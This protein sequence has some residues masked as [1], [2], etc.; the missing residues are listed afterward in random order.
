MPIILA[1]VV[2]GVF[3]EILHLILLG[4]G[5]LC[6]VVWIHHKSDNSVY[7]LSV[8]IFLAAYLFF[9]SGLRYVTAIGI[10][11]VWLLWKF[12]I[13]SQQWR[14]QVTSLS[15]AP[16]NG[17]NDPK[18]KFDT[19][20]N[21]IW[22]W[23]ACVM[24][25][26]FIINPQ[27]DLAQRFLFAVLVFSVLGIYYVVFPKFLMSPHLYNRFLNAVF[28]AGVGV[29]VIGLLM[30]FVF[31]T[32]TIQFGSSR[33]GLTSEGFSGL[34]FISASLYY[35][36]NTTALVYVIAIPVGLILLTRP[37]AQVDSHLS[38]WIRIGFCIV[39]IGEILTYSRSSYVGLLVSLPFLIYHRF[40]QK[41]IFFM[42]PLV[43]IAFYFLSNFFM[44]KGSGSSISRSILYLVA[45]R[46]LFSSSMSFYFGVGID[47]YE[48]FTAEKELFG[49]NDAAPS[50]HNVYVFFALQ[51]GILTTAIFI[52]FLVA[53]LTRG[54]LWLHRHRSVSHVQPH[55]ETML[56]FT[57]LLLGIS[58]H[59]LFEDTIQLF[60]NFFSFMFVISCGV[61]HLISSHTSASLK[62]SKQQLQL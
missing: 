14:Q 44:A 8:I 3:A 61:I 1:V 47:G 31:Q 62:P 27:S 38:W 16:F 2:F 5:I 40:R 28:F 42:L 6:L 41:A 9:T 43:P 4:I 29:A 24:L 50:P 49:I 35:H 17:F 58:V 30:T 55:Y 19:V 54:I 23:F 51:F 22:I 52:G 21:L 10:P 32:Y 20:S 57:A 60:N 37:Q 45:Y 11:A 26:I 13:R 36:P 34:P 25:V 33:L 12:S 48:I 59:Q 53:T 15:S 46:L 56:I 39:L 7:T 18:Q